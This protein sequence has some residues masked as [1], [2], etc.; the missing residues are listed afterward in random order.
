MIETNYSEAKMYVILD[1]FGALSRF[2]YP[3]TLKEEIVK[4][5]QDNTIEYSM[6]IKIYDV[7][8]DLTFMGDTPNREK[9]DPQHAH[10]TLWIFDGILLDFVNRGDEMLFKLTWK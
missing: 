9:Y 3:I 5:L 1:E 2:M 4:W 7:M 8:E 6:A 10:E